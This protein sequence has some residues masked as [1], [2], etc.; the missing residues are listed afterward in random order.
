MS[1]SL[2]PHGLQPLPG[3][4]V[5]GA[6]FFRQEFWS[7]LPNPPPGDL[8]NPGIELRSPALQEDSSSS[9]P[10]GKPKNTGVGSLSFSRGSS[11]PRYG[12]R[13]SHAAGR[14]SASWASREALG[15]RPPVLS[16][17]VFQPPPPPPAPL[18]DGRFLPTALPLVNF[19]KNSQHLSVWGMV[20]THL[21]TNL[22]Y[23]SQ[24]TGLVWAHLS[25]SFSF[26]SQGL[27]LWEVVVVS[28]HVSDNRLLIRMVHTDIC[29][30]EKI[31]FSAL[32]TAL[33]PRQQEQPRR[34]AQHSTGPCLHFW[35]AWKFCHQSADCKAN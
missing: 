13:V 8:S 31:L 4:Y 10:Q 21:D 26:N 30:P 3:S 18:W 1:N 19:I 35:G 16:S 14:S 29:N 6:E 15:V 7:G 27:H 17:S 28:H 33:P 34:A 20:A 12:T 11:Q 23:V 9:E 24:L 22:Q 32:L 5:H 25:N 2:Q